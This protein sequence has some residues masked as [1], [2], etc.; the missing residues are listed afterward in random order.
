MCRSKSWQSIINHYQPKPQFTRVGFTNHCLCSY[1]SGTNKAQVAE[2]PLVGGTTIN[3]LKEHQ[4]SIA[5]LNREIAFLLHHLWLDDVELARLFAR[6]WGL[7]GDLW[8]AAQL[9]RNP[10]SLWDL[11]QRADVSTRH[12]SQV[13]R[14]WLRRQSFLAYRQSQPS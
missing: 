2:T 14:S 11:A 9:I 4:L 5:I 12:L 8:M 7:F 3:H 6:E 13:S 1:P 10:T